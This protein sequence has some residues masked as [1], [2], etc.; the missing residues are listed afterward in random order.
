M[1]ARVLVVDDDRY[2]RSML[3]DYLAGA[4]YAVE[5]TANGAAALTIVRERRPDA[6]LLDLNM[7]GTLDGRAVL[8]A[9]SRDC[10]VI[11]ITGIN[12][13]DDARAQLQGGAFDVIAKPFDLHH[14]SERV[15]AAVAYR[16]A[17]DPR[18]RPGPAGRTLTAVRP[19]AHRPLL[20]KR[21]LLP[22]THS[23]APPPPT[24]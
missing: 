8:R 6:V 17:V 4:G 11:V 9:I 18:V 3:E 13:P 10:P 7:P 24:S 22:G 12:D 20:R 19:D 16:T 2:V 15:A 5:V 1:P 21:G 23:P 14:V